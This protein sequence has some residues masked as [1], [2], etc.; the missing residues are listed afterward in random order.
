MRTPGDF[1]DL[2]NALHGAVFTDAELFW[3]SLK[4]LERVVKVRQTQQAV[5][6][7]G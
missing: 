4:W 7:R 1:F 3:D 6:R 5:E 2:N